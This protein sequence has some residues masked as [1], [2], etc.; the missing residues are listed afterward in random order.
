MLYC[1]A[2]CLILLNI[3]YVSRSHLTMPSEKVPNKAPDLAWLY[4][5][6]NEK[7]E[8]GGEA[9]GAAGCE[10]VQRS[11]GI[12][13]KDAKSKAS[14]I[15][16]KAAQ[17]AKAANDAQVAAGEAAS[18]QVKLE[19]ADKA[20]QAARAAEAALAGKQQ[21]LEQLELEQKESEAVVDEVQNSLHSTQTNADSAVVAVSDAKLQLDQLRLLVKEATAQLSN[22]EMFANGAQMELVE[23]SQLLEAA[24]RRVEGITR[25]V[26]SARQDFEKTKKAAYKAACAA[27]EAKQKAQRQ[28]REISSASSTS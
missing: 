25:Q 3:A 21:I 20:V 17:D 16:V 10:G 18:M 13:Q 8:I 12:N 5:P 28:Q 2:M 24:K 22:I 9:S 23:K 15:A 19:L 7:R 26:M 6:N 4:E 14:S 27:V 11:C 1:Q